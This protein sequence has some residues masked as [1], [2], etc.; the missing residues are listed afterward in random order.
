MIRQHTEVSTI[1]VSVWCD[2]LAFTIL[3]HFSYKPSDIESYEISPYI[4]T[5]KRVLFFK[6]IIFEVSNKYFAKKNY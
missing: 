5:I 3:N 1:P 4:Y 6:I 2:I